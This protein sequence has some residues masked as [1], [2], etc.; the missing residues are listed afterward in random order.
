MG[1]GFD[2]KATTRFFK[3][4][5]W[6]LPHPQPFATA[7]RCDLQP[8]FTGKMRIHSLWMH[9]LVCAFCVVKK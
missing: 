3:N 6:P 5:S 7:K 4:V 8:V 1:E 9:I 2:P